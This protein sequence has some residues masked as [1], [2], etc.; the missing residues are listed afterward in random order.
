MLK[1]LLDCFG[2]LEVNRKERRKHLK[3]LSI[4][5]SKKFVIA[6]LLEEIKPVVD[7]KD[8]FACRD[9]FKNLAKMKNF[10][11]LGLWCM[12]KLSELLCQPI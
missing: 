11:F 5:K 4:L 12:E 7:D 1:K 8:N 3:P 6:F 9:N 10:R 2:L